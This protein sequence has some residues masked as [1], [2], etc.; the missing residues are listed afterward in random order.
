MGPKPAARQLA[1]DQ[2]SNAGP[3]SAHGGRFLPA[4]GLRVVSEHRRALGSRGTIVFGAGS[5]TIGRSS[6]NDWIYPTRP[7]PLG[8]LADPVPPWQL[9][10]RGHQHQRRLPEQRPRRRSRSRLL[11]TAQRRRPRAFGPVVV[12]IDASSADA[13]PD[14]RASTSSANCSRRL[15][16][17]H[18]RIT[19]ADRDTSTL[20]NTNALFAE[21]LYQSDSSRVGNAFGQ[22]VVLPLSSAAQPAALIQRIRTSS[23]RATHGA[24]AA[25]VGGVDRDGQSNSGDPRAG[26]EARRWHPDL[27]TSA[28]TRGAQQRA[29]TRR[30]PAARA[31]VGLK[32]RPENRQ[33]ELRASPRAQ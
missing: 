19:A 13:R 27:V 14:T 2:Y 20:L 25:V 22:A 8:P 18:S 1:S 5:S 12:S 31:I 29:A 6:E 30:P 15:R 3:G 26:L 33:N 16:I 24:P 17:L 28:P 11:R 4:L 10:L 7:I 32:D 21:G 23:R 9:V